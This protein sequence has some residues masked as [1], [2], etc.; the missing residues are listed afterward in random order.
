MPELPEVETIKRDL[1]KL[2][3]G[4]KI[5]G[6]ST[7]S[8]KQIK[9]SFEVIKKSA[10]GASIDKIERRAKLLEFFL[11]NKRILVAHLKLTGRLLV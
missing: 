10:V 7:D 5:L 4:R 9:P 2:I 8:P 6:I 3:V 11:S 1:S